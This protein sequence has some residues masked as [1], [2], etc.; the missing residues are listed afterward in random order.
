M[1][2]KKQLDW[3]NE[4]AILYTVYKLFSFSHQGISFQFQ[5]NKIKEQHFKMLELVDGYQ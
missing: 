4:K 1:A 5:R 3:F 2:Q